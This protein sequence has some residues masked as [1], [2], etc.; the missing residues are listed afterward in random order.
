MISLLLSEWILGNFLDRTVRST[1]IAGTIIFVFGL[2]DDFKNIPPLV[3]LCGQILA[4]LVLIRLG[5]YVRI[6]ESPEFFLRWDGPAWNQL[7]NYLDWLITIFW[8][9]GITNAF[10]FVDS[11]D[12]L[13]VGLGAM[14]AAFFMVITL[15]ANQKLLSMHSAQILGVCIGLYLFN[16]P[17]ALLFIGDSGAQTLGFILAALAIA[18]NPQ[19]ANQSSS[20][21]VPILLLGVPILDASLVVL[22]RLKRRWPIYSAA[23]D[24][25]YHRLLGLGLIPARAVL[26]MQTAALALGCLACIMLA[27][28]PLIANI[29]F[30]AVI[31]VCAIIVLFLDKQPMQK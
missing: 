7:Y 24:H 21:F 28:P 3:K 6:F 10:N 19:G 31:L 25:T 4:A 2:W 17:P 9:V 14:A 15:D 16:S 8:V 5:V 22:S 11:M 20:W 13:A 30:A 26:V 1:F 27:Q 12:G 23:R 18:Y 29:V